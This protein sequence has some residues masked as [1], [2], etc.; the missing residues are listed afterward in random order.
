MSL[1]DMFHNRE[2][3]TGAARCPASARIGAVKPAGEVR[4]LIGGDAFALVTYRDARLAV[5]A[6]IE[7]H[8]HR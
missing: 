2:A 5:L 8:P 7:I 4:N 1:N 6:K 3:Q